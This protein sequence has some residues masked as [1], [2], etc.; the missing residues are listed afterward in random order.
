MYKNSG[1]NVF[2]K[3]EFVG[4]ISN[5]LPNDLLAANVYKIPESC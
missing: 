1:L 5:R 4:A 3:I 2:K